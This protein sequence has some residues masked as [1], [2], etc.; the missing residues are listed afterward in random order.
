METLNLVLSIVASIA[1][2]WA[3]WQAT[4]ANTRIAALEQKLTQSTVTGGQRLRGDGNVQVGG[5]VHG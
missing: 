3:A 4:S 2:I 1:S 5:N